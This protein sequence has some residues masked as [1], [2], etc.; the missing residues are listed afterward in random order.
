MLYEMFILFSIILL[1]SSVAHTSTNRSLLHSIDEIV[2]GLLEAEKEIYPCEAD[3]SKK[4][5][6]IF[7]NWKIR[8]VL[9]DYNKIISLKEIQAELLALAEQDKILARKLILDRTKVE[10]AKFIKE[11]KINRIFI[12]G[13]YCSLYSGLFDPIS[14]RQLIIE[15][16]IKIVDNNPAIH[17]LGI[18]G[19]LQEIMDM[20][21]IEI[22]NV[23]NFINDERKQKLYLGFASD[24]Q[25]E[26]VPLQQI[27]IIPNSYLAKIVA[28][29]LPSDKNGWFSTCVPSVC[30]RVVSNTFK[31][32]RKL[33]LLGYK[34]AAFSSNGVIEAIEDK[35]G[36]IFFQNYPE[37]LIVKS[38]RR[39]YSLSYKACYISTL[40]T[41]AIINDFLH[42]V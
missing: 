17:L 38:D 20:K 18:C 4:F 5:Y 2:V 3:L 11:F 31:N 39:C 34:V 23:V 25:Q 1:F 36:N 12:L 21:G 13:N 30:S 28:K 19:S 40:V 16:I 15:A 26:N 7:N 22:L 35:H 14:W 32:R 24:Q 42:R 33:E 10:V 6:E 37:A 27:K 9:I 29:F 8:T 41:M